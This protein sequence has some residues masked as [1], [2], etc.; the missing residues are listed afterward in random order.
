MKA[1]KFRRGAVV[2]IDGHTYT[3]AREC[4]EGVWQ[5]ED[6][7]SG[8]FREVPMSRLLEGY[9]QGQVV[10][11]NTDA[12]TQPG[13]EK[14]PDDGPLD[15]DPALFEAA[16]LRR[17]YVKMIGDLPG[18][19]AV[20]EPAIRDAWKRL[21]KPEKCPDRSSVLR[22]RRKFRDSGGD[23]ASLIE[24]ARRKGNRNSRFPEA[25]LEIVREAVDK[26]YM[27]PERG[28]I[29]DALDAAMIM[30]RSENRLLAES[31]RLP[32]P[33]RRLVTRIIEEIPAY[34]RHAARYG[35]DSANN[36]FRS[37]T[38]FRVV[39]APLQRAEMDHTP[40]D[41][42]V[43]DD[44]SGM[45]LGRPYLTTCIDSH[46]RCVL[47]IVVGFEPPSYLTV[48]QCLKHAILPKA[49]LRESQPS[50]KHDWV[51]YGIPQELTVDNGSEF[52][53][54]SLEHGCL[55]LGIEIHYAPRRNGA[56]KGKIERFQKTMNEEIAHG[57][58]GTTFSNIFE[59][60]DYDPA[61]Q[62]VIGFSRFKEI[63]NIWIVDVYHQRP[64]RAL[65]APP[66]A[67]WASS[68]SPEDIPLPENPEAL[69]VILGRVE[70]GRRLSHKG[71]ELDGL[72][73]NS[74]ELTAIRRKLGTNLTV[75]LRIDDSDLGRIAVL[76]PKGE[77]Y[78][79][80]RALN[81]SYANGLTRWQHKVCRRYGK[82]RW[83][84]DGPGTWLDA[85]AEISRLISEEVI[86][87]RRRGNKRVARFTA[88][89]PIQT[90]VITLPDPSDSGDLRPPKHE[91]VTPS[92]VQT[93][94]TGTRRRFSAI[95]SVRSRH[96]AQM[97]R[98][99]QADD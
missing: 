7:A 76:L 50:L 48:A 92:V 69:D 32:L 68:I 75:D 58:P 81:A 34:D 14:V 52:H 8:R 87:K 60:E 90:T 77:G 89:S 99:E 2:R 83:Q 57:V 24:R 73:Y 66:A 62:A 21:G 40:L 74:P 65:G 5:L 54:L 35:R 16:R 6:T 37:V 96:P 47:G 39:D 19:R 20:I 64:H 12:P 49:G 23:I 80:A 36:A 4:S 67:V 82:I 13:Q 30:V 55:R 95:P 45:P 88:S 56:F 38:G 85:K 71:I 22:W 93:P 29:Q 46:S 44:D 97:E 3:L 51:S 70:T 86:L 53:S 84:R 31:A 27:V 98:R 33:T 28:T 11:A 26:E 15:Y 63:L 17:T 61:R 43:I 42:F 41:L 78:V 9:V 91:Q 72:F 94:P 1:I 18:T 59:K 10:F 79:F 25:V